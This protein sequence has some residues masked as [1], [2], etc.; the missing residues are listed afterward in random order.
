MLAGT[1]PNTDPSQKFDQGSEVEK[2]KQLSKPQ[3]FI[4]S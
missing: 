1:R 3:I 2:A 4:I